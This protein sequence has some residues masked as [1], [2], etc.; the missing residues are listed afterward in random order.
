MDRLKELFD[1]SLPFMLAIGQSQKLSVQRIVE[2][3]IIAAIAGGVS[4]YGVTQALEVKL[5]DVAARQI[6]I[7]QK[8]DALNKEQST[9][10]AAW[11]AGHADRLA[12]QHELFRRVNHLDHQGTDSGP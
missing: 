8:V 12:K 1:H 3:I 4:V 6:S 10:E 7:A 5:N 9:M 11:S 2:A